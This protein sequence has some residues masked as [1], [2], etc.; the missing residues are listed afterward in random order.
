VTA[1]DRLRNVPSG[2]QLDWLLCAAVRAPAVRDRRPFGCRE[3]LHE[4]VDPEE[5][6]RR[7]QDEVGDRDEDAEQR[8]RPPARKPR[9][10]A[11]PTSGAVIAHDSRRP[12][13]DPRGESME[14][15][16][17]VAVHL[18]P[19]ACQGRGHVRYPGRGGRSRGGRE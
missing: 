16:G 17:L 18:D 19:Y 7:Y 3:A 8:D 13:A 12:R 11:P 9:E 2:G 6:E 5:A 1:R 15:E 4:G 14:L 10:G